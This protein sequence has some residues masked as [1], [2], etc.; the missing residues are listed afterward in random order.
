MEESIDNLPKEEQENGW[1]TIQSSKIKPTQGVAMVSV[2]CRALP[3]VLF[4][5]RTKTRRGAGYDATIW[6]FR[7][8]G[9]PKKFSLDGY[10]F[11]GHEVREVQLQTQG[12]E[13]VGKMELTIHG[14]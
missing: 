4:R 13:G 8:N 9:I 5:I 7:S 6:S 14:E 2:E 1:S 11:G 10:E 3:G 12:G